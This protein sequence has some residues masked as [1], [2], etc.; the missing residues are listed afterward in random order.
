VPDAVGQ[1]FRVLPPEGVPTSSQPWIEI[2]GMVDDT[3]ENDLTGPPPLQIYFPFAQGALSVSGPTVAG[4]Q[5]AVR[6]DDPDALE[7]ELPAAITSA[8]PET[9]AKMVRPMADWVADSFWQR[10][11]L[12]RVLSALAIASVVLSAIGL[13]GITSF[14]VTQRTGEVGIRRALGATRRSVLRL[15]LVDTLRVV[16]IGVALGVLGSWLAR[17]LLATFL[18]GVAALDLATYGAVGLGVGVVAVLAALAPALA[19]SRV[20]P[21]HALTWR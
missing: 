19:A 3:I 13:F 9:S 14:A 20:S 6:G 2:I 18:F 15:V 16:A 5:V 21:A 17:Q 1:R 10:S 12:S 4:F 8:L 7:R 11:A